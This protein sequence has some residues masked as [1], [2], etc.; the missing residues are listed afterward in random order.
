MSGR[1]VAG[2]IDKEL[3]SAVIS[4]YRATNIF[5][6]VKE[7]YETV[8]WE[9]GYVELRGQERDIYVGYSNEMYPIVLQVGL[10]RLQRNIFM[11]SLNIEREP[12]MLQSL[13]NRYGSRKRIKSVR[14]ESNYISWHLAKGKDKA[15]ANRLNRFYAG[16]LAY[17]PFIMETR[18]PDVANLSLLELS[19]LFVHFEVLV[20]NIFEFSSRNDFNS[21]SI[22]LG[23]SSIFCE[24]KTSSNICSQ[25][26]ISTE[27]ISTPF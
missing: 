6:L 4:L 15:V 16:M 26:P 24:S 9:E 5:R 18:L 7:A 3:E 11:F 8:I 13:I 22:D 21:D 19:V 12:E 1:N 2:R 25:R 17:Y 23:D 10:M 27:L 20:Q 14:K